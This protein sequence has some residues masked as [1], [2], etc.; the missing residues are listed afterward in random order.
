MKKETLLKLIAWERNY[1][2][3]YDVTSTARLFQ[4]LIDSGE[5]QDM[6]DWYKDTAGQLI[7]MGICHR[8]I[9]KVIK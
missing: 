6:G 2:R 4:D 7:S 3:D 9:L 1:L 5:V 8:P